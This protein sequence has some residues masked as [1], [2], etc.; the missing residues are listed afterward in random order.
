MQ[1]RVGLV[2]GEYPPM[3]GGVGSFTQELAK[4]LDRQGC[5]VHIITSLKAREQNNKRSLWSPHEP[6]DIGFAKLHPRINRWRWSAVDAIA[7]IV[8]E[9]NLQIVNVQ[10]QAAAFDMRIP[11][12]N[13]L[14][15]RLRSISKTVVTFHDLRVPYL[16]P[17]AGRLRP[18]IIN[19][20]A[21]SADGV[22]VT[23]DDD[24]AQLLDVGIRSSALARIPIGS[25]IKAD[26]VRNQD[27]I[28]ALRNELGLDDGQIFLGYFGF[29]N[30]SKGAD[31]LIQALAKSD[32][33]VQLIF[34]GASTGSSDSENR[35]FLK[36]IKQ[37]I[38]DF[39]LESRIH[40]SGFQ[41]DS[42]L[43]TYFQAADI[44]VMPYR[45]G[46]TLR[47]GTLMAI[48]AQ[49]RP[50]I[51]TQSQ[52]KIPE[53][54]HGQNV[55]LSPIDDI[56]ALSDAIRKLSIDEALRNQLALGAKQLSNSFSWENIAK[57]TSDF[58]SRVLTINE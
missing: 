15:W 29:L 36:H 14:P 27:R 47:R 25:N 33:N 41:T 2:T 3:E 31:I 51:T 19:R 40:W 20:L 24:M 43:S 38:K 50:L 16:F 55:W 53:L 37:L 5:E 44:M 21:K 54:V 45:D 32:E 4:A 28:D 10:F 34:L 52:S 48:L 1:L 12:I 17:K 30:A 35:A 46:V 42:A 8:L 58:Y 11:A 23:N 13:G 56:G 49:G 26:E 57:K 7:Q 9:Y 22:I 39:Q 6:I 18:W